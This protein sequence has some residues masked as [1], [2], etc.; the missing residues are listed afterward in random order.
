M[1]QNQ[2]QDRTEEATPFK[3][4]EARQKGMVAKSVEL[5]SLLVMAAAL[6]LFYMI[7]D[8]IFMGQLSETRAVWSSAGNVQLDIAT[9]MSMVAALL[10]DLVHLVWPLLLAVVIVAV[11]S[12]MAQTGPV[13]SFFP[14]K[15]DMKRLNPVQGFKRIFSK[16]MAYEFVKTMIK[17]VLMGLVMY[18]F[19]NRSMLE[20]MNLLNFG[21][22][23][24]AAYTFSKMGSLAVQLLAVLAFVVLVDIVYT[25]WE[26]AQRMRMSRRDVKDEYKRREGD[27]QVRAKIR[28]LQRE[29]AKRSNA[30]GN[31]GDADVL[32]T[33][34][35]H[36]AIALLYKRGEMDAPTVVA[37]GA[38]EL[39]LSMREV[40]R[41]AG[42]PIMEN[43]RLARAL[44]KDVDIDEA[45][46]EQHFA[47][48]AKVLVWA[49]G[50]KA[51]RGT[52][53]PMNS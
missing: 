5:T 27:P 16:R 28:E 39:A 3:L 44:F 10:D 34:P 29:A 30:L 25:R 22:Q 46:P 33:N 31:V 21:S 36:Y 2:D 40:A 38:G 7:G 1:E 26:F 45:V 20:F 48:V 35:T 42:V 23:Q 4:R 32:I 15:P 47:K 43:K 14:L 6:T 8:N 17:L 37:K 11:L 52:R 51:A 19:I 24:Q 9:V 49:Y 53:Q 18:W 12:T 50:V 13:F 41:E